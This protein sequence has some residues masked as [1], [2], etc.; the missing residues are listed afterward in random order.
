MG[1]QFVSLVAI[2]FVLSDLFHN[3]CNDDG[4]QLLDEGAGDQV[5]FA[6]IEIVLIIPTI[7]SRYK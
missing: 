4:H 3:L 2:R 6:F 7:A 5:L 1:L